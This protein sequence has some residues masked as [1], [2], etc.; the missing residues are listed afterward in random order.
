MN[1]D[2]TRPMTV[3]ELDAHIKK[4][5]QLV[6]ELT[7]ELSTSSDEELDAINN[8]PDCIQAREA[9]MDIALRLKTRLNTILT[10]E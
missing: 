6:N 9:L 1:H 7:H 3:E 8:N 5:K 2:Q 4:I 10:N